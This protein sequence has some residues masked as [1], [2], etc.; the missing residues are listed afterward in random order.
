M[1]F[2]LSTL[3]KLKGKHLASTGSFYI[4]EVSALL[5]EKFSQLI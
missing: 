3:I 2:L 5:N 4:K 1:L